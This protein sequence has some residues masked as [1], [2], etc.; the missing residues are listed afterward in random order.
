MSGL[1]AKQ[2]RFIEEYLV[3]LNATK[4]AERAGYSKKTARAIGA[5]NLTKPDIAAAIEKAKRERAQTTGITAARVLEELAAIA[6]SD[7]GEMVS[8]SEGGIVFKPAAAIPERARRAL[9]AVKIK[10][11]LGSDQRPPFETVEFKLWDKVGALRQLAEHL[12][13]VHEVQELLERIRAIEDGKK[14]GGAA[15]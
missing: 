3:D 8:F 5:E 4:A 15:P 10:R 13:L 6:F 11:D 9:A 14:T 12:G 1:T 7:L 2:Q